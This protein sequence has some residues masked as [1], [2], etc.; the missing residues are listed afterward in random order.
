RQAGLIDLTRHA[1]AELAGGYW[2]LP[3]LDVYL[4]TPRLDQQAGIVGALALAQ[5]LLET[6]PTHHASA[7]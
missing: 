4:Q 5:R 7:P 6:D 3:D 2:D 1:F